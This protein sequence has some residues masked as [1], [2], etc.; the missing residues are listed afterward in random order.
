MSIILAIALGMLI[1][2]AALV[3]VRVALGPAVDL[4]TYRS[5]PRTNSN[6]VAAT[7]AVMADIAGLLAD[8]RGEPAPAERWDP[9]VHG[10]KETGRLESES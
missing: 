1:C 3:L 7:D 9:A 4:D 5:G 6:L 8:L 2:A 10:Q